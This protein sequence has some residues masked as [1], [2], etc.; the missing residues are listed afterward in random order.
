MAFR[1]LTLGDSVP[2]GQGL[3]EAEKLDVLVTAALDAKIAG[4]A[5]LEP[6]LA[7]SGAVIGLNPADGNAA[8][9]EVPVARPTILEQCD[10]FAN[11][12]ETVDLVLLNGGINDVGVANILNPFALLP[13]LESRVKAACFDAMVVLL[14]KVRAK[15]IKP[16]CK[17]LVTGYYTIL[18]NQSD[19]LGVHKLLG[20]HGIATPDFLEDEDLFDPVVDRCEQFFRN[21]TAQ[22]Q[23]AIAKVNDPRISYIASGFTDDNAVFAPS[24]LLFGLDDELEP[25][26]PVAAARHAQ[27]DITFPQ[28]LELPQREQ[29]YR[30]SAGHP[31]PAGAAQF[32]QKILATFP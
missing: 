20:L 8:N 22:L 4:G 7:H 19:P 26:D 28:P 1:I 15:F 5:T 29:C 2:W 6:R 24:P 25:V 3:L 30:A 13:T 9:G 27:C 12:P 31:N 10:A 16:S 21:S 32:A 23:A 18:S 14:N 17:I 11:S